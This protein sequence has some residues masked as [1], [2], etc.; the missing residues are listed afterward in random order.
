MLLLAIG[1][2]QRW[3]RPSHRAAPWPH[4]LRWALRATTSCAEAPR[5]CA[6]CIASIA[7]ARELPLTGAEGAGCLRVLT[8]S[9][10]AGPAWRIRGSDS[11]CIGPSK[12]NPS[13]NWSELEGGA[14]HAHLLRSA[15]WNGCP[16]QPSPVASQSSGR[17]WANAASFRPSLS[18]GRRLP[19]SECPKAV[20]SIQAQ[21]S[22]SHS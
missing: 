13:S 18:S 22:L 4:R 17:H 14:Q 16:T 11:A 1:R 19:R 10:A 20:A 5:C 2:P 15:R 8:P 12:R 21:S 7:A 9:A 6:C 3:G